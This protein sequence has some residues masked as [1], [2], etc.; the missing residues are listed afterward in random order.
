[1]AFAE[2]DALVGS[3]GGADS[4]GGKT[5]V[6]ACAECTG[7][8]ELLIEIVAVSHIQSSLADPLRCPHGLPWHQSVAD[9]AL[10]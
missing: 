1:M 5:M 6:V 7:G 8:A 4:G 9:V 10:Q 2:H 3:G